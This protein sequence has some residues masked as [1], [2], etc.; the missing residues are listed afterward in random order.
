MGVGGF[1]KAC[2]SF[3]PPQ[4]SPAILIFSHQLSTWQI[5]PSYMQIF[6]S[7]IKIHVWNLQLL[8]VQVTLC[9]VTG[10]IL[11]C[12]LQHQPLFPTSRKRLPSNCICFYQWAGGCILSGREISGIVMWFCQGHSASILGFYTTASKGKLITHSPVDFF[13]ILLFF[14]IA[15]YFCFCKKHSGL[16]VA[17]FKSL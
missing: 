17:I 15:K 9:C 8:S 4:P 5:S 12:F 16:L 1:W 11:P 14:S 6:L 10:Y 3:P 2:L 7:G 13:F